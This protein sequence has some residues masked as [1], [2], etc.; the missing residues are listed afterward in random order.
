MMPVR[1][2]G[3]ATAFGL[4]VA[5]GTAKAD[6]DPAEGK[7]VFNKCKACHELTQ[8]K[9]KV[10]PHLVGILGRPVASVDG[11]KYSDAL[12]K[13]RESGLV[14]DEEKLAKYVVDPKGFLPGNRMA[15][16]G[17][18]KEKEVEDLIAYIKQEQGS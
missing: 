13:A 1:M 4:L 18:K 17:L 3:L 8:Q 14:W 9:N 12:M 11:F 16:A 6:G 15:F 5:V 7:R 2:L 10:G